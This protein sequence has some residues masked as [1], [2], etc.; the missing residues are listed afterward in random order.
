MNIF[1]SS[2]Y[3]TIGKF[4]HQGHLPFFWNTILLIMISENCCPGYLLICDSSRELG[5]YRPGIPRCTLSIEL[6]STKDNQVGSL[7]IQNMR[8]QAIGEVVGMF[9]WIQ[10]CITTNSLRYW[11]MKISYLKNLEVSRMGEVQ[12]MCLW[13]Y[14]WIKLGNIECIKIPCRR[15]YNTSPVC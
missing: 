8:N 13:R 10:K 15:A 2:L 4:F 14:Y 7:K 5:Q 11:I 6:V 12:R 9:T 3:Q 1:R